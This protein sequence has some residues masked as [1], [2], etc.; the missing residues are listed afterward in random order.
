LQ[1]E[2]GR[3]IG[4]VNVDDE[5]LPQFVHRLREKTPSA[6]PAENNLEIFAGKSIYPGHPSVTMR[7]ETPVMYFYPPDQQPLTLDVTATFNGGVLSECFPAGETTLNNEPLTRSPENISGKS[8][9][10]I[11]W[12]NVQLNS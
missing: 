11:T 12:K 4:G 6:R 7:L 2:N 10:S 5:P 9:G 3:A 8:R 1:D